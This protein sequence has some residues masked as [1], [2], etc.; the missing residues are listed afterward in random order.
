[1]YTLALAPALAP[2]IFEQ[3]GLPAGRVEVLGGR[4]EDLEH[5]SDWLVSCGAKPN[6]SPEPSS[7]RTLNPNPNPDPNP[8]L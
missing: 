8:K 3:A 1:M 7:C 6:P 5:L 4:P 2:G